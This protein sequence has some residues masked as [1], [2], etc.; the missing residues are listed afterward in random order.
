MEDLRIVSPDRPDASPRTDP[1][2]VAQMR[3]HWRAFAREDAMYYVATNR[4]EWSAEDFY[5]VGRELV[6][7]VLEWAG[8]SVGRERMVEIGCGAGRLLVH[9]AREF[10]HVDGFDIA[11]EMIETA[12]PH[13]PRNVDLIIS[14]GADL[15]PLADASVDFAFSNQVFQHI[16]DAA[17]IG[18]YVAE[19]TRVLRPGARAVLHFDTRPSSL[20]RRIAMGLPDRLLPRERRRYIRRYPLPAE[21]PRQ[22]AEEAGLT[23]VDERAAATD[24]HML[25]LER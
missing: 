2:S 20:R 16:P 6:D 25:L 4:T 14:S 9:F 24:W 19:T 3:E 21:W 8:D 17:V 13:M 11:A 23:V 10:E 15:N 5:S 12:R 1:D 7:D 22:V 18:A